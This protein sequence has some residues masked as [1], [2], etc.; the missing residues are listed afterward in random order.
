M[1]NLDFTLFYYIGAIALVMIANTL[2]GVAKAQK[3]NDFNWNTLKKGLIKY[4]LILL[5]VMF[6]FIAGVLLPNFEVTLPVVDETVTIIQMLSVV[7]IAILI[8]YVISCYQNL[9]ELFGVEEEVE[10]S[11]ADTQKNEFLG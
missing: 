6:I 7:A 8:K 10:K 9:V 1:D 2:F 5:G 3:Y 11:I 4:L